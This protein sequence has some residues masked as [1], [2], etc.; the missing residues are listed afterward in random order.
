MA[1]SS[2]P[3]LKDFG[4]MYQHGLQ[5]LDGHLWEFVYMEPSAI[6]QG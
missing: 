3:E 6:N 2:N 1:E 5:D 4:L